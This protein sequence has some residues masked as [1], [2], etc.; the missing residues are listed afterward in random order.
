[1]TGVVLGAVLLA[2]LGGVA[3]FFIAKSVQN[4]RIA[5]QRMG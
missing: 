3:G 5:M 2:I 4:K 1:M